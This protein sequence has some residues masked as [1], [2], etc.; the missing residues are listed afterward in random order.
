MRYIGGC[1]LGWLGCPV[2]PQIAAASPTYP[3][4]RPY[5]RPLRELG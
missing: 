2:N 3:H 4:P 1:D 5:R